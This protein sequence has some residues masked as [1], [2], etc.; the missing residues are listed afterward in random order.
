MYVK[1]IQLINYG[2]IEEVN[3]EMAFASDTPKPIV[4]VGENGSGKSIVLSHVV[5]G[6]LEAQG[7]V[8]PNTPEVAK[9]KV[10]KLRSP[11]YIK[12]GKEFYYTNVEFEN[13]LYVREL[14]TLHTKG[15]HSV[16]PPSVVGTPAEPMW[17]KI[18]SGRADHYVANSSE[19]EDKRRIEESFHKNCVLY[20]PFNR[21][22]EPAWLNEENLTAQAHFVELK[23][24]VGSTSRQVIASS[25]LT[26]NQNWLFGV[27]YDRAAFELQTQRVNL[28]T[29]GVEGGI[30]LPVFTGYSGYSSQMYEAA[31]RVVRDVTRRPDARFGIGRRNNRVVS[32]ESGSGQLVPNIFQLSSGET[33]LLNLFLS[34]LRDFDLCGAPFTGL[35]DVRGI[36]VVDE[37]DLHLHSTY[38][39][40]VLPALIKAFPK[41]QFIVTTHSPLF[42]LGMQKV[43]GDDGFLLLQL[44]QGQ[45][46][47]PEEFSEFGEAYASFALTQRF[48]KDVRV[49]IEGSSKPMLYVEGKT[50]MKYLQRA[51]VLLG[52]KDVL[53]VFDIKD[54]EGSGNLVKFWDGL[55]PTMAGAVPHKIVLLFDWDTKRSHDRRGQVFQRVISLKTG[56]PVKRGVENLLPKNVLERARKYKL[57]FVESVRRGEDIVDGIPVEIEEQWTVKESRKNALCDW[58]IENG[59]EEEFQSF[60]EVFDMLAAVIEA[61][62]KPVI[63]HSAAEDSLSAGENEGTEDESSEDE[64]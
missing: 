44:P 8:F 49:A 13:G 62:S 36:A 37:I 24:I 30:P 21:F 63:E 56:H 11:S 6:L 32:I 7:A 34:I 1:K 3:L 58:V 53:D 17:G 31:L 10:Y 39:Y 23:H 47:S 55:K 4:L 38:Q 46:I 15:S 33:A 60:N 35:A 25:P 45:E 29:A 26:D 18:Q 64:P 9:G 40:E 48:N 59:T 27:V 61:D 43:M 41:V 50:D 12:R 51:A 20:F 52:R 28:P 14:Q 57:D 16:V 2:P 5:N 42:V 19:V 54:G 22:E